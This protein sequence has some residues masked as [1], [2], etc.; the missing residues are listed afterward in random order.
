MQLDPDAITTIVIFIA[1]QT[2]AL[3]FYAGV[4]LFTVRNHEKL[5]TDVEAKQE[6]THT[7]VVKLATKENIAI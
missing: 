5:L 7:T 1:A 4:M 2:G 3:I 6:K